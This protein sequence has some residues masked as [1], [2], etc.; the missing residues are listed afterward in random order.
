MHACEGDEEGSLTLL[1]FGEYENAIKWKICGARVAYLASN[2]RSLALQRNRSIRMER[3]RKVF[4]G[5][6]SLRMSLGITSET[7]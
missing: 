1:R 6:L 4:L 7:H 3:V 5:N 2:I